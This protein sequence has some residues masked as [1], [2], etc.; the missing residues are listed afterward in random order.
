MRRGTFDRLRQGG[1]RPSVGA[2]CASRCRS[3]SDENRGVFREKFTEGLAE[4]GTGAEDRLDGSHG[5]GT[6]TRAR[7]PC[8]QCGESALSR[9]NSSMV[10]VMRRAHTSMNAIAL[11]GVHRRNPIGSGP[12]H[13]RP[14]QPFIPPSRTN[15]CVGLPSAADTGRGRWADA[16]APFWNGAACPDV[17]RRVRHGQ[18]VS[19]SGTGCS[20]GCPSSRS[21]PGSSRASPRGIPR[22]SGFRRTARA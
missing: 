6:R 12:A 5:A 9:G 2:V 21:V 7:A 20:S 11:C 17:A 16:L 22:T 1:V 15:G 8:G 10:T 18:P 13:G 14:A 19:P 3:A 4:R